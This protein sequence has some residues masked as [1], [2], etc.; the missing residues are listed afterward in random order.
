M[1][2]LE[3]QNAMKDFTVF[4]LADIRQAEPGFH[5][6]RLNE[7]QEKGYI[8]KLVKGY[9]VFSGLELDE[10]VI[11]EIAN[12]I[13]AP[14]YVSFE[15]ALSYY[16]LI[17]ESVFGVTSASTRKTSRFSTTFGGFLYR[18]INTRLYFGF[19]IMRYGRKTFKIAQPE[20]AFLDLFY[21]KT[22]FREPADFAAMRVDGRA[23][24]SLMDREKMNDY[25]AVFDQKSL[26]NRINDFWE[27]SAHA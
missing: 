13:Y 22:E 11:F 26:Q 21:I 25:L 15:M 12:R 8:K 9:Y 14:S 7:W 5:R 3:F 2:Y 16:G 17:P 18:T 19:D 4:S 6:R 24:R 1:Q 23:F 20:K 10:R 27:Y